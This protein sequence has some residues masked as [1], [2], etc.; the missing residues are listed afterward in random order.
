LSHVACTL[1]LV[2]IGLHEFPFHDSL[3][4]S[5]KKSQISMPQNIEQQVRQAE[6]NRQVQ[7]FE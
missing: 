4:F 6:N 1:A 5:E 7:E 2:A 3:F